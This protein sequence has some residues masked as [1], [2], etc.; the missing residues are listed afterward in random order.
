MLI[1]IDP[2][3]LS[4]GGYDMAEVYIYSVKGVRQVKPFETI[5]IDL[6]TPK[7]EIVIPKVE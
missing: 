7:E 1:T 4:K 3:K 2:M 6:D 5:G